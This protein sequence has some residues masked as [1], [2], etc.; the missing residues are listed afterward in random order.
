MHDVLQVVKDIQA[1]LKTELSDIRTKVDFLYAKYISA[2]DKNSEDLHNTNIHQKSQHESPPNPSPNS[3]PHPPSRPPIRPTKQNPVVEVSSHHTQTLPQPQQNIPKS[4]PS[5]MNAPDSYMEEQ[6]IDDLYHVP[7][8]LTVPSLVD[9]D[10]LND[11]NRELQSLSSNK[12]RTIQ[13]RSTSKR[14]PSRY[15]ISPYIAVPIHASTKE[16]IVD[17]GNLRVTR[18][19]F[20]TLEP[21]KFLDI[22]EEYTL[23]KSVSKLRESYMS[24]LRKCQKIY[25]PIN[26]LHNHW[27]LVVFDLIN[28]DC[29]IWDS[30]PPRRKADLTRLNQVRKLM[31]SLDIVLADDIAVAFPTSFS[32]T[33]CSISYAEASIQPNGY[34]CGLFVCM[35][36]DDNCPTPVQMKSFQ[37]ECQRLFWARFLALFPGNTNLLT[38]KKNSQ[39]HYQNLVANKEV[40]PRPN[41]KPPPLKKLKEGMLNNATVVFE[42][43]QC[44]DRVSFNAMISGYA[45]NGVGGEALR[46]YSNMHKIGLQADDATL[47]SV[48]TACSSLESLKKG[49]QAHHGSSCLKQIRVSEERWASVLTIERDSLPVI[50][51]W[52]KNF[53][54]LLDGDGQ[55]S[56]KE[57]GQLV[58]VQEVG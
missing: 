11:D 46:L 8:V 18:Q 39:Q 20:R 52:I 1:T 14:N 31:Q 34:D 4:T 23:R 40:V 21:T 48:F 32:F 54:K 51:Q 28:R 44:K 45:Q 22:G 12:R 42:G 57:I 9:E 29:Q 16:V 24:D 3:P 2:E 50:L 36:M 27:Y 47:V 41:I 55:L 33:D 13:T 6:R 30:K 5:S 53:L 25:I 17:I 10:T 19:S 7:A 26:D 56:D 38:L 49:G 43:I 37:S 58:K 35:F 15:Q